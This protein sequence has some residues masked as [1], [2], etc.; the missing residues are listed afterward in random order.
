[1][2]QC[3]YFTHPCQLFTAPLYHLEEITVFTD[4]SCHTQLLIGSWAAILF[5]DGKRTTLSGIAHDTTHN[6]MELQAVIES[7]N[8]VLANYAGA[9]VCIY[10]DSQYVVGLE[11][12]QQKITAADHKTKAGNYI[13]NVD[14]VKQLWELQTKVIVRFVK[15]AAH[16]PKAETANYNIDVDV[17]VR[18]ILRDAV[19]SLP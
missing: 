6:R 2:S 8:Y 16:Q 11:A 19:S 4:G 5:N 13:Q 1:M 3:R 10:S 12:R 7:L 14:L 18:G 9:K 17:V 15:V